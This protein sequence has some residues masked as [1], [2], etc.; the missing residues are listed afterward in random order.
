MDEGAIVC[1]VEDG[2]PRLPGNSKMR[3]RERRPIDEAGL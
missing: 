2:S 1:Q 3:Q